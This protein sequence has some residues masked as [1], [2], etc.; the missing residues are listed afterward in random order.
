WLGTWSEPAKRY[1]F[2]GRDMTESRKAQEILRE[3]EHLAR[4][5]VE[6]ALDAFV[7][8][9]ESDAI[10]NWNSQAEAIFGWR[11]EGALGKNLIDLIIDEKDHEALRIRRRRFLT[12][13]RGEILRRRTELAVRRRNGT[14]FRAELSVTALTTRSGVVFNAFFRDLTDKIAAE[15]R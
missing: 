12:S 8:T 11:R 13:G 14:E 10:L 4:N 9:D 7:Q 15:E 5:I 6:T 3:S 2:V 1:F